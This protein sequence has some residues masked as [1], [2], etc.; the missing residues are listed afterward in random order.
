MI[1]YYV[2]WIKVEQGEGVKSDEV[3]LLIRLSGQASL[4][5]ETWGS[6]RVSRACQSSW[7][8][9]YAGMIQGGRQ[10]QVLAG[11]ERVR[12]RVKRGPRSC[13]FWM[14][15]AGTLELTLSSEM[16]LEGL[17]RGVILSDFHFR[18]YTLAARGG[19][20]GNKEAEYE[21]VAANGAKGD[22]GQKEVE[23]SDS[24]RAWKESQ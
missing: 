24:G 3:T 17:N 12:R 14:A 16:S 15:M 6:C 2:E 5:E 21:A 18:S 22:R 10:R 7:R 1:C 20:C 4:R 13:G 9:T 23:K 8:Q 11:A 19:D